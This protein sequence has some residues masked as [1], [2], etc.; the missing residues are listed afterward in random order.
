MSLASSSSGNEWLWNNIGSDSDSDSVYFQLY[1][2][3]YVT[4]NNLNITRCIIVDMS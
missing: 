1:I 2:L 3:Q 4:Y